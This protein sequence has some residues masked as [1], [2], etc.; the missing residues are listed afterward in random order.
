MRDLPFLTEPARKVLRCCVKDLCDV[1]K[2]GDKI[3]S[4][5]IYTYLAENAIKSLSK[6]EIDDCISYLEDVGLIYDIDRD[7]I[8][9]TNRFRLNHMGAYYFNLEKMLKNR[10][11]REILCESFLLPAIVSIITAL[12]TILTAV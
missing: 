11:R 12:L 6:H 8:G 9:K 2:S 4:H 10:H 5:M 1:R 3:Q 7:I